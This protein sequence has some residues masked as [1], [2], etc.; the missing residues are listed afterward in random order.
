MDVICQQ[1]QSQGVFGWAQYANGKN[2]SHFGDF[3]SSDKNRQ[4]SLEING[5][6]K[7]KG[8]QDL[9]SLPVSSAPQGKGRLST[10]EGSGLGLDDHLK[11]TQHSFGKPSPLRHGPKAPLWVQANTEP[12]EPTAHPER[13]L[14]DLYQEHPEKKLEAG[15][16]PST[17]NLAA[18]VVMHVANQAGYQWL[19]RWFPDMSIREV[20]E[21]TCNKDPGSKQLAAKLYNVPPE[22]VNQR[23]MA[24]SLTELYQQCRIAHQKTTHGD[25]QFPC[26]IRLID[27]CAIF[28]GALKNTGYQALLHKAGSEFQW[29]RVNL[30]AKKLTIQR[31]ARAD[32]AQLNELHQHPMMSGQLESEFLRQKR[33]ADELDILDAAVVEFDIQR[34]TVETEMLNQLN[35]LLAATGSSIPDSGVSNVN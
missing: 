29:G 15:I 20:F 5:Q 19:A 26:L 4:P 11:I 9:M 30:D 12:T 31:Q 2:L 3:G 21:A 1:T 35:V 22:A 13:S 16:E 8:I 18:H 17:V 27:K 24:A 6:K 33:Q 7:D 23:F 10:T 28:L 34:K 14:E 25:A 32:L